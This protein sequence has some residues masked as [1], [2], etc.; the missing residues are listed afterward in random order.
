MMNTCL[1]CLPFHTG[2][3]DYS[4]QAACV[5]VDRCVDVWQSGWSKI[6]ENFRKRS[7][8]EA[9]FC[10]CIFVLRNSHTFFLFASDIKYVDIILKYHSYSSK[11]IK[12][13]Y[14]TYFQRKSQWNAATVLIFRRFISSLHHWCSCCITAKSG[15]DVLRCY[16]INH[17]LLSVS[18]FCY[19]GLCCLYSTFIA[20][21][22]CASK[23]V[24]QRSIGPECPHPQSCCLLPVGLISLVWS[25]PSEIMTSCILYLDLSLW[26]TKN[27][28]NGNILWHWELNWRLESSNKKQ[29]CL[30]HCMH[31]KWGGFWG[32]NSRQWP[33]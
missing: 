6:I 4:P 27:T 2:V 15:C 7:G 29:L 19:G 25:P 5:S 17:M 1:G 31:C 20:S 21:H 18:V 8:V 14:F 28:D 33:T 32:E 3:L 13:L 16:L 12:D 22:S 24:P 26:L 9:H 23:A 11:D 30:S 10:F